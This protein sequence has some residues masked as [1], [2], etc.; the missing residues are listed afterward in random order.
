MVAPLL[1]TKLFLPPTRPDRVQRPHLLHRLDEMLRPGISLGLISCPAG[2][3]KTSLAAEWAARLSSPAAWLSLDAGDNDPAAFLAY[4]LAALDRA[5]PGCVPE[6]AALLRAPE[7][8]PA[9]VTLATLLNELARFDPAHPLVVVLDDLQFVETAQVHESLAFVVEHLPPGVRLLIATRADPALPLARMRVRRQLV[10][11]RAADL[12]FSQEEAA[13][14]FAKSLGEDVRSQEIRAIAGALA[15]RTEGWAAGLQMAALALQTDPGSRAGFVEAFS[16]SHRFVLDYLAEEVLSRRPKAEEQFLLLTAPLERFNT[17]LCSAVTGLSPAD[18]R[19]MLETFEADNLFLIPLDS[20]REWFRYHYLFAD[21]LRARLKQQQALQISTLHRRAAGWFESAGLIGEAIRHALAAAAAA[22]DESER[23]ADYEHAARMVEGHTFQLLQR[24]EMRAM[25]GWIRMLPAELSAHRPWLCVYRAWTLA[26]GGEMGQVEGLLAQAESQREVLDTTARRALDGNIAAIHAYIA[27][28]A[29]RPDEVLDQ[30]QKVRDLLP[31]S[32]WA[33]GFTAW[34]TGY[35]LRMVGRLGEAAQAFEDQLAKARA[36]NDPWGV[37][38]NTTDLG[39]V[40]RAQGRLTEALDIYR[41]GLEIVEASGARRLGY[42]GRLLTAYASALYEQNRLDEAEALLNEAIELNRRWQNAN[43]EVFALYHLAKLLSAR[44]NFAGAEELVASALRI[45]REQGV[46]PVLKR[47]TDGAMLTLR[48]AQGQV[49][50][51]GGPLEEGIQ[52]ALSESTFGFNDEAKQIRNILL[53]RV[54][55][56]QARFP[57]VLRLLDPV[58]AAARGSGRGP[59]LIEALALKSLALHLLGLS[60]PALAALNEAAA[61]SAPQG[62]VRTIIDT[63]PHAP[64]ALSQ[65]LLALIREP[66]GQRV[67]S[68]GRP[69]LAQL[70]AAL[71]EAGKPD[72]PTTGSPAP[73]VLI[74]PISERELEVLRL[75]AE[76]LT[77]PQIAARL[78]ISTGTV[79]AHTAAIFRKLD[80]NTRTQAVAKARA[81]GFI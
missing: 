24:G 37:T 18:C 78:V 33:T 45:V 16:G 80:A 19:R 68:P 72:S 13:A 10:E 11:L 20:D 9:A 3:G 79:K 17:A 26:L 71:E 39:Q 59:V 63:A 40:R 5:R 35:T 62:A 31:E 75:L 53:A 1:A 74:E 54:L 7:A 14:F 49:P 21:L 12:R 61:L 29:N 30:A 46:V 23:A 51:P 66:T 15:N 64:G 73:V 69:F 43:H 58:E 44:G 38:N 57:E 76:G 56:A 34:N 81:A 77:N 28:N 4:L 48:L 8:P 67:P 6:T 60:E 50:P 41:R 65:M 42:V 32:D 70:R 27:M 55:L 25:L 22:V 52:A 2:F 47:L 36:G